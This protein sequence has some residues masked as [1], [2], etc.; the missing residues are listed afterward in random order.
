MMRRKFVTLFGGAAISLPLAGRAQHFERMRR[1]GFL[2]GLKE[3]DPEAKRRTTAFVEKLQQLGWI[4]GH[5]I[6]IEYRWFSDNLTEVRTYA[7]ELSSWQPDVLVATSTPAVKELSQ[8]SRATIPIVFAIV[9]D[10]ISSGLVRDLKSPGGNVTGFTNFEFALGGKWLEV[11]KEIA[12]QILRVALVFNPNTTPY[13]G[14]LRSIEASGRL[15][16]VELTTHGVSDVT[17]IEPLITTTG[18]EF[19][20]WPDRLA[21]FVYLG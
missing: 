4:I 3:S 19:E 11:L 17:E 14:Y 21:G 13:E 20:R 9:T 5:N 6:S 7:Q 16:G 18:A 12:P 8:Q 1:V 10:P 2:V 15:L